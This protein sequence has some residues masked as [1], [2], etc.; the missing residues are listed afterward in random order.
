M[1]ALTI[2]PVAA[3]IAMG[4]ACGHPEDR[5]E[6]PTA[7]EAKAAP[8]WDIPV[9]DEA[10]AKAAWGSCPETGQPPQQPA[11]PPQQGGAQAP[12]Q[13]A[14]PAASPLFGTD[15]ERAQVRGWI[16]RLMD[17]TRVVPDSAARKGGPRG[18]PG[19]Y[20]KLSSPQ[21]E[22]FVS[23]II[24]AGDRFSPQSLPLDQRR[25]LVAAEISIESAF[26]PGT[27][28]ANPGNAEY[29]SV[30]P[31]QLTLNSNPSG[32]GM[33]DDTFRQ[34]A[35][36]S[37]LVHAD[38]SPWEPSTT[39]REQFCQ[40]IFDGV[41]S[42]YWCITEQARRGIPDWF[43]GPDGPM[44]RTME[45]AFLGWVIGLQALKTGGDLA[46]QRDFYINS[47]STDLRLLGYDPSLIHSSF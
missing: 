42:A 17:E 32:K 18:S 41:V 11:Q 43:G 9:V 16:Q 33:W 13:A 3:L 19:S 1:R 20:A 26:T 35:K 31:L 15:Q 38:G 21:V 8:H 29:I 36:I 7:H 24:F 4:H 44:P 45:N 28:G 47:I 22:E 14:Q 6:Q 2:V 30:G 23:A 37:G 27:S 34:Y 12:Q 40:S 5:Q 39:S 10:K 25:V 46:G